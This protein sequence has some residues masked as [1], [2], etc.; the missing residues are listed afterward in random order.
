[1]VIAGFGYLIN[2][3]QGA[4]EQEAV[5]RFLA[6]VAPIKAASFN[7]QGRVIPFDKKFS[8]SLDW[9]KDISVNI[10]N[11]SGKTVTYVEISATFIP[12]KGRTDIFPFRFPITQG[13]RQDALQRRPSEMEFKSS[14]D[15]D[16]NHIFKVTLADPDKEY[17]WNRK[18]LERLGYPLK[19][20]EI[21]LQIQEVVFD[22]GTMWSVGH[23]YRS[24]PKNPD[25]V[26]RISGKG[27]DEK[28][29][30][31]ST[32][33]Y[34]LEEE[35]TCRNPIFTNQTCS[36][37]ALVVAAHDML[38]TL[39][40]SRILGSHRDMNGVIPEI[41]KDNLSNIVIRTVL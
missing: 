25:K 20:D 24:D 12:P 14:L 34:G 28:V 22:D 40:M 36:G 6:G 4:Q 21:H 39:R 32:G 38:D 27:S 33:G 30:A 17:E 29:V 3:R 35:E 8:G 11:T 15:S 13:R 9:F 31:F 41:H 19:I 7:I 26:I 5:V 16:E 18:S 1:M 10:Q 2:Y 23:W 37:L